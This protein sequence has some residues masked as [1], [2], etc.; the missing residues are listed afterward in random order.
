MWLKISPDFLWMDVSSWLDFSAAEQILRG[1]LP[2]VSWF[3]ILPRKIVDIQIYKLLGSIKNISFD[4]LE[5]G[6]I[7][8]E[9]LKCRKGKLGY[10]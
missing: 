10:F 4:S 2:L 6:S 9:N 3:F 1:K 8:I 7:L 5:D